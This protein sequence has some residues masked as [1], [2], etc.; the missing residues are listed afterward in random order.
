[1]TRSR[2]NSAFTLLELVVVMLIIG[3]T[4]AIAAP[5]MRGWS[6]G[7]A[8]RNA[9][10]D[11]IALT[12][13]ARSQAI[14]DATTYRLNVDVSANQYWITQ[15]S[16]SDFVAIANSDLGQMHTLP[17]GWHIAMSNVAA[18][19]A[20]SFDFSATGRS[21]PGNVTISDDQGN[22]VQISCGTPVENFRVVTNQA[23]AS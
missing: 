12:R 15:Q 3:I 2:K 22:S 4:L 19:N 18:G 10:D 13:L 16:G 1:M 21:D 8:V 20:A 7:M 9:G 5:S 23:Q 11:F 14:A 6:H 17:Q